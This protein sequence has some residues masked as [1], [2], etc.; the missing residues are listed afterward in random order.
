[1]HTLPRSSS[2]KIRS[3]N[4][5]YR[6]LS[7][8][9]GL[10]KNNGKRAMID[11]IINVMIPNAI[12]RYLNFNG[13]SPIIALICNNMIKTMLRQRETGGGTDE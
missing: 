3:G 8:I 9:N 11:S 13:N 4:V 2:I 12:I 5:K 10:S 1:M 7:L 6:K